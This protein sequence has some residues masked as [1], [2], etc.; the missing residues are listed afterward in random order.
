MSVRTYDPKSVLVIVGGVP[1]SEFAVDTF[2]TVER[3]EDAFVK[4]VG[5]DGEVSRSKSNNQSGMLT[6]TLMQTSPSNLILSGF[7]LVDEDTGAGVI[8]VIIKEGL[9]VIFAAEG[10]IRKVANAEFGAE[11]GEREWT[12]DLAKVSIFNGGNTTT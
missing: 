1:M 5:A 11:V 6:L 7:A 8:P 10:W 2:V 4:V 9:N 12:L 3:E